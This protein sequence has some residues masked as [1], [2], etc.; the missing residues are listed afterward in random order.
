MEYRRLGASDVQISAVTFGAWA[1]GGLFWGGADEKDAIDA[2]H[3]SLDRGVTSIDT[4]PVYGAGRSER[5]VGKAIAGRRDRVQILTKFGMRWDSEEGA[6]YFEIDD[7]D[8]THYQIKK[9]AT[10]GSVI[11]ECEASLRRLGTDHIDLLQHHTMA[12]ATPVEETFEAVQQLIR[13]GKVRAAGVSNYTVEGMERASAVVK[14]ASDQ[15]PYSMLRR[16]IED[17]VLPYCRRNS[18]GAI[19]Y[20]PLQLGLLS[21][22]VGLDR[23]FPKTDVRHDS[24]YF[25]KE[26]RRRVLAFLDSIRP[27]AEAH[28]ATLAQLVI[29][30][31]ARRPGITAA[32]VGARNRAQALENAGALD[33]TLTDREMKVLDEKVDALKLEL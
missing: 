10:R 28:G 25:T 4:A 12:P 32:L 27:I 30:W 20:S 17:D 14:I 29:N 9:L 33:F 23:T 24:P 6:P 26:N 3:A 2:I 11:E 13:D 18:I 19:V 22:K 7:V 1:I 5:L 15:P 8:G 16:A 21:G 31:T